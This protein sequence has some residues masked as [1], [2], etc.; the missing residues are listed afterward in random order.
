MD[1]TRTAPIA[2]RTAAFG[3]AF[4]LALGASGVAASAAFADVMPTPTATEMPSAAAPAPTEA[5][6]FT[7]TNMGN[8]YTLSIDIIG[9]PIVLSY[10]VDPN[11]AIA[12]VSTSTGTVAVD[13]HELTLTLTDGRVVNV[14]LGEGGT[15]V[16][17]VQ[18]EQPEAEQSAA[19]EQ[20]EA[21]EQVEAP[22]QPDAHAGGHVDEVK[23]PKAEHTAAP[24]AVEP[25]QAPEQQHSAPA[26]SGGEGGG[27]S[28]GAN[29]SGGNDGGSNN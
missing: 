28:S 16:K 27:D 21:P 20:T 24:E 8:A 29:S 18:V 13:G 14:E 2:R 22:E 26:R 17:E 19:P 23:A 25:T 1:L 12:N 11:G 6:A 5:P 15:S 10:T 7:L 9:A 3:A 4:V